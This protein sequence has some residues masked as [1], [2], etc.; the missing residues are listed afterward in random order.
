MKCTRCLLSITMLLALSGA[1]FGQG[2]LTPAK[3]L[4][5]ATD[6]WATY[7]G[8]YSGRRYSPLA[9]INANNIDSLSLAWVFRAVPGGNL[10]ATI[11]STPLVVNGVMYFTIPDH[12]WALD[13]RTGRQIWH[14]TWKSE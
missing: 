3:L 7:N 13:A 5:P 1:A 14:Y 2:A 12:V 8:D 10:N 6:S 9:K 11:K 4:Q